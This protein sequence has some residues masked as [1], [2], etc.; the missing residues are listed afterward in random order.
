[1]QA[2]Y[3][4]AG[5]VVAVVAFVSVALLPWLWVFGLAEALELAVAGLVWLLIGSLAAV[6]AAT[7]VRKAKP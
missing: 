4:T 7:W 3:W 2:R 6:N 1:M 5:N